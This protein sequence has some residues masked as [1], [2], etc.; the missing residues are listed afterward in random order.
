MKI[1]MIK[2]GVSL[3]FKDILFQ[4]AIV[5]VA[6]FASPKY[7]YEFSVPKYAILT[8]FMSIMFTYLA[9]KWIK[10]KKISFYIT[11]AH[12][13]WFLFSISS[14]ISSF[15]VLRDNPFYFRRSIDIALYVVFNALLAIFISSEYKE[16]KRIHMFLLTF[17]ITGFVISIDALLNFYG[18]Y[19]MFLGNVGEAF[20]RAAIKS[21]VGN[22]IFTANYI[23]MLLP[24][25]LYFILSNEIS[26][27]GFWQVAFLKIFAFVSFAI[28]F[29][30]VIVS[31]TR[32]EYLAI[33]IMTSLYVIMYLIWR[34]GK[35]VN[36]EI[37][38]KVRAITRYLFVSL[39][40]LSIIIVIVFNTDN[41][42]TNGG[43]VSM[44]SRF[45]AMSSVSSKD[46]RFLSWFTSLE[47][48]EDHKIFGSGIATYQL[49]SISKMGE[50]LEKHPELY[51]GWNNFKRAHNDYFQVLGETGIVG[52]SLLIA[53]LII[54]AY[55]F[56]TI[57]KKIED[58]D[59][60]LLFLSLSIS[61]VGFAIQSFF[62]FPGHLLPNALAATFFASVAIGPY[63]TKKEY[64]QIK[65]ISAVVVAVLVVL[66]VYT[67]TYLRWNRFISEVNFKNGNTAYLTYAKIMEEYPKIDAYI[68]QLE[69]RLDDLRNYSG[70][71][72][73]LKPEVW[74][75]LKKKEYESKNLPYNEIEIENQRIAAI[76]N[77]RSQILS[78]IQQLKEQKVKLPKMA[79]QYYDTAKEKLLK[80]VSVEHT[81]GKSYFYLATLCVQD[82]RVQE[83]K[84]N[85]KTSYEKIFNQEYDD[86]QKII[87]EQ[88][89]YKWLSKLAPYIKQ[90][91]EI[92]DKFDFA[93]TQ[94]LI[95]SI[96]IYETSLLAFNERN[97]YKAIAMRYHSLHNLFK[98]LLSYLPKDSE[99]YDYVKDL[100]I[101]TFDGYVDY[102]KKTI[103]NMPGGWNRFPDWKNPNISKASR[104]QDIYRFFAGMVFKLQP[105][106][107]PSV[108]EFLDWLSKMEIKAAKYM[109]LKG[110]WGVPNGVI[111][112]VHATAFEYYK[113]KQKNKQFQESIY[114]LEKIKNEYK[115]SY[116]IARKDVAK[117]V[118]SF[119]N[120]MESLKESY[121]RQIEDVLL[122]KNVHP[123]AIKV[124][125]NKFKDTV[126][127]IKEGFLNY[128]YLSLEV[129]YMKTLIGKN[130]ISWYDTAKDTIWPSICVKY[131]NEFL[132]ELQKLGLNT[133]SII[134]IK[135][136]IEVMINN[137]PSYAMV[138]ESYARFIAHYI[139]V[140]NDLKYNAKQL[141]NNY[142]EMTD[143][144]WE[145]VISDWS[146]TLFEA[147]PLNTKEKIIEYLENIVKE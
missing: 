80:S 73:Q 68:S 135:G 8:L 117:Y 134:S 87:A 104:G 25:A 128:N 65:G 51:Y 122:S 136:K 37:P 111:D 108:V 88:Y 133:D 14:V 18:G 125:V 27:K 20:S 106:T 10:E 34:K 62:S 61:I 23:D 95:D 26:F 46:E 110:I 66:L 124:I 1:K 86:Y 147:T 40:V 146:N 19:S 114:M 32:S 130:Y 56:F 13:V 2:G 29:V 5:L 116:E 72:S 126:D 52:F 17:M 99:Y 131:L 55:Y 97:T 79:K 103:V 47:L 69:G 49:L 139:L 145:A 140:E 85:I 81:Y 33:I 15:N 30:A 113:N 115:E 77:V 36:E 89:K 92:L 129:T 21:T 58:R 132:S 101:K 44:T 119:E 94:A 144:M 24:I 7:T 64:K 38:K 57:P 43:K 83:M 120:Q 137:P 75:E 109:S 90:H 70:E 35:K 141:L 100:V 91:M 42:L 53:L 105:P 54:L 74:K 67:T 11:P 123:Q 41:P 60:L 48:W 121:S 4:I 112:F 71:F 93:T 138:Y 50:Y 118:K 3:L 28:G 12:I 143:N 39:I 6:L 78:Q 63:F 107:I 16:K 9:F 31:Q 102:S 98:E 96:G 142:K 82:F 45:S 76:N 127:K 84:N 22:V 59:D